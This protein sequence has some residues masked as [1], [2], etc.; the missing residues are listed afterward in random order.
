MT[1]GDFKIRFSEKYND[2]DYETQQKAYILFWLCVFGVLISTAFVFNN[3]IY[4]SKVKGSDQLTPLFTIAEAVFASISALCIYNLWNKRYEFASKLLMI[5]LLI[6]ISSFYFASLKRFAATGIMTH[7]DVF[8]ALL[9]IV[10]LFGT[11]RFL[12]IVSIVS[13][14]VPPIILIINRPEFNQTINFYVNM[15]MYNGCVMMVVSTIALY[16]SSL[17]NHRALTTANKELNRNIE[18]NRNLDRKVKDRTKEIEEKNT[19]L[20]NIENNLKRYLPVQLVDAIKSGDKDAVPETE[21]RKLTVFFSDIKGFT[22]IT[23]SLEAEELSTLLNEYLTEMT[24]IA[25]KWGG[26]VDKFIGDA[27]MIFFGA[28]E[29]TPDKDNATNCV[30]MAIEMQEKMKALQDKWFNEGFE[31]PLQIRIGIST[32]TSTVGNFGAEDRL[33]Y[34]VIG[35]QVNIAARLESICEPDSIIISHPT[36]AFVK[37]EIEC[38]PGK[39][40]S[41]KGI[42]R[43]IMTYKVSS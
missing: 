32:G 22:D 21:R 7:R 5:S 9:A 39:T 25:H 36:W 20:Q 13:I 17:I 24:E 10:T 15:A 38:T 14:G 6:I 16:C 19:K 40:V 26:T 1:L 43:E 31:N 33:S 18:L 35:G 29:R 28:P 8:Y 11:R 2:H 42:P 3:I 4:F 30:K 12:I 27:I 41:V 23:E 34:T 37:D